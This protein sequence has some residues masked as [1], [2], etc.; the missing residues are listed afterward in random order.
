MISTTYIALAATFIAITVALAV[1]KKHIR[2]WLLKIRA[3]LKIQSLRKAINEADSDK[4]QTQRK[5]IVVFNALSGQFEAVPK[6]NLKRLAGKKIQP[7][8]QSGYRQK[9]AVKAS[10]ISKKQ[11][12]QTEK[13][14]LYVT[15]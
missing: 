8:V 9:K 1:F 11:V 15:N 7:I 4:K 10:S 12:K 13:K 5:N 2:A 3:K 14:S 6:K